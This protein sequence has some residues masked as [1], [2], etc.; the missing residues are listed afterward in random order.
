MIEVNNA[1]W[2]LFLEMLD[3]LELACAH[4][5][6]LG[7]IEYMRGVIEEFMDTI[8]EFCPEN[9]TKPKLHYLV[10]YAHQVQVFGPLIHSW[11]MRLEG[12]H[13]FFKQIFHGSKNIKNICK[14]LCVCHQTHELCSMKGQIC[15]RR[16]VWLV[17]QVLGQSL[18]HSCTPMFK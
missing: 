18:F 10:H 9:R 16:L 2:A 1:Y 11:T 8:V 6:T 12:K 15:S 7:S 13:E 17:T 4:S 3:V 14:T 5:F